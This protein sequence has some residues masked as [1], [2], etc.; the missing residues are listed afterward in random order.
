M[1]THNTHGT[2]LHRN[3]CTKPGRLPQSDGRRCTR[4]H[5]PSTKSNPPLILG[6][7]MDLLI[8]Q[9]GRY[10]QEGKNEQTRCKDDCTKSGQR[11]Q[12]ENEERI[13]K[14]SSPTQVLLRPLAD[15]V[16]PPIYHRGTPPPNEEELFGYSKP[17]RP[18][19]YVPCSAPIWRWRRGQAS[20]L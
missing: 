19:R 16:F 4:S 14:V 5:W 20:P 15:S 18:A 2:E 12:A 1:S 8:E 10:V 13:A 7:T 11:T 3:Q 17:A 9:I 6:P